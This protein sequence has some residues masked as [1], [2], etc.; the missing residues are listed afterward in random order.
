M[1]SDCWDGRWWPRTLEPLD[2]PRVGEEV[3]GFNNEAQ[4]WLPCK[5]LEA[6]PQGEPWKVDWWDNSQ[7]DRIKGE[8]ELRRGRLV[9]QDRA[10]NWGEK[11]S[12][13]PKYR[14]NA[15]A[16]EDKRRMD[17]EGLE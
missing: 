13:L 1:P 8:E 15:R 4:G 3:L 5:I 9:V 10:E 12:P 7:E 14:R 11:M 16:M 17:A 2:L 6:A